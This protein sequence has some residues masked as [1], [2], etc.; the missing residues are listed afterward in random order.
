MRRRIILIAVIIVA[1]FLLQCTVFQFLSIGS[2]SPNLLI[3]VTASFGFMRGHREGLFV[4]FFCG[5]LIDLL[6]SEIIGFYALLYMFIGFAN[7]FF[8]RLFYPEDILLPITL[9]SVSDFCCNLAIYFVLF[10]FRGRFSFGYYLGHTIL[11][12]LVY[13]TVVAILLY[14]ILLRINQRLEMQERRSESKLV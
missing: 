14:F 9:I 5:L 1:C 10:M 7:G 11:P 3:V 13:T 12:E 4:G 8:H 6:F 2:I